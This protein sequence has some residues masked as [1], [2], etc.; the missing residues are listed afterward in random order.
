MGPLASPYEG[1][2][3]VRV[4]AGRSSAGHLSLQGELSGRAFG[5]ATHALNLP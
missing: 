2:F 4:R 5:R 3:R 1:A